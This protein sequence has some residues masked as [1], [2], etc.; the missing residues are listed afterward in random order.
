MLGKV[1]SYEL[2]RNKNSAVTA[3]NNGLI[4]YTNAA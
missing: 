3:T 1:Q 2:Y 4:L